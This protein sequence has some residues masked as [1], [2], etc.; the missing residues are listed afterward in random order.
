MKEK[1]FHTQ[2]DV[3]NEIRSAA[4]SIFSALYHDGD[5]ELEALQEK[6][7]WKSP[8]FD[9]ALGWL[10]GKEDVQVTPHNASFLLRRTAPAPAVFPLRGD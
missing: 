1:S 3:Q 4:E 9:W 5:M 7:N 8:I 2:E 10:V 6:L